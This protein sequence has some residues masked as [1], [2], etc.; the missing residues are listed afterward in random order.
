MHAAIPMVR[1]FFVITGITAVAEIIAVL[2]LRLE[3]LMWWWT[4]NLLAA[5]SGRLSCRW[6]RAAERW[7]QREIVLT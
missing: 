6:D 1:I 3:S 4:Y 5:E 7:A 2:L